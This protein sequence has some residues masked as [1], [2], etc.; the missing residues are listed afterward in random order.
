MDSRF[1]SSETIVLDSHASSQNATIEE[2]PM[3]STVHVSEED[4]QIPIND[5]MHGNVALPHTVY[6]NAPIRWSNKEIDVLAPSRSSLRE[7]GEESAGASMSANVSLPTPNTLHSTP[8]IEPLVAHD[9]LNISK[10]RFIPSRAAKRGGY[11][12]RNPQKSNMTARS[13]INTRS[14]SVAESSERENE[15]TRD[16]EDHERSS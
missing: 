12:K 16:C 5:S 8:N 10:R 1:L 11:R 15:E 14:S 4:V 6:R 9:S 3:N 13:R 2:T 7:T